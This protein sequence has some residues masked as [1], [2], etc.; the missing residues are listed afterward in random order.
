MFGLFENLAHPR[1]R[2]TRT[3]KP[4]RELS[5]PVGHAVRDTVTPPVH[6]SLGPLVDRETRQTRIIR[7]LWDNRR[8]LQRRNANLRRV[9]RQVCRTRNS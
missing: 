8:D 1:P 2:K 5:R 4:I 9:I 3:P 6:V 7:R